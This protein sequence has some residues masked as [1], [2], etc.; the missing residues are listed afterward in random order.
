MSVGRLSGKIEN[1]NVGA[2]EEPELR[3]ARTDVARNK[4]VGFFYHESAVIETP[5]LYRGLV[6]GSGSSKKKLKTAVPP[7]EN[8]LYP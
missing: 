7:V 1:E 5:S 3:I 2:T 8:H 4:K 6:N